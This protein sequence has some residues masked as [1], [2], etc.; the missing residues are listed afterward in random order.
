MFDP[1]H[2]WLGIPP[3][4]QPPNHYRLLGLTLFESDPE[5]IDSAANRQMAYL[6]SCANGPHVHFSQRLLNDVAAA[7]LC[8]LEPARRKAYEAALKKEMSEPVKRSENSTSDLTGRDSE[9]DSS[10][11]A[12][13]RTADQA[14]QSRPT[15]PARRRVR[16]ISPVDS[17]G[18]GRDQLPLE[19]EV[20]EETFTLIVEPKSPIRAGSRRSSRFPTVAIAF[21]VVAVGFAALVAWTNLPGMSSRDKPGPDLAKREATSSRSASSNIKSASQGRSAGKTKI[22]VGRS[23]DRPDGAAKVPEEKPDRARP[24]GSSG[25]MPD[26]GESGPGRDRLVAPP[27]DGG[28]QAGSRATRPEHPVIIQWR[29]SD[30]RRSDS[31]YAKVSSSVV[32]LGMG[33]GDF[34]I[35]EAGAEVDGLS[36]VKANVKW[37]GSFREFDANSIA[38]FIID[39]HTPGGYTKRESCYLGGEVGRRFS[40]NPAWGK[41]TLPDSSILMTRRSLYDLDLD[42]WAPKDWDG[43][44]WF[45]VILQ[46]TGRDS[47]LTV[48]LK[49]E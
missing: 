20:L 17:D 25:V 44:V 10:E 23:T 24:G 29:T 26:L 39:Y 42:R 9:A 3:Q 35:G 41:A 34:G 8:L 15:V 22:A 43:K 46:N 12:F 36:R 6:Q 49:F 14:I 28:V 27:S 7:R 13:G 31:D 33:A 16:Q 21:L 45:T 19:G 11:V 37:E 5:V 47:Q 2:K 48:D 1:Y 38:G 18:K 4:E 32:S 40:S 30:W